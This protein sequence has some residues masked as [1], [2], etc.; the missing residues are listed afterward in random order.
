[1]RRAFSALAIAVSLASIPACDSS[2]Q[3]LNTEAAMYP[4][5]VP[6]DSASI[7]RWEASR[8]N[9]FRSKLDV[10]SLRYFRD[11]MTEKGHADAK[12]V[13]IEL[14][15]ALDSGVAGEQGEALRRFVGSEPELYAKARAAIYDQYRRSYS[16]YKQAWSMGAGLFGGATDLRKVL[17]EI[18]NGNELDGLISFKT[19]YISR[20]EKGASRIGIVLDCPWD[21]ENGMGLVIAGGDVERVGDAGVALL[22]VMPKPGGRSGQK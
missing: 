12:P 19:V 7:A 8:Y 18:A 11:Q 14:C 5:I 17:P 3:S 15:G 21:E 13:P 2:P 10:V 20:P 9:A 22:G 1:M 16:T 4:Q 6:S